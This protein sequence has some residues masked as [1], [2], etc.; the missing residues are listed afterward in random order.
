[1]QVKVTGGQTTT[2]SNNPFR[3]AGEYWAGHRGEY[4][5]R[6]RSMN[7]RTGR[8]TQPDPFFHSL[9]GNLQDCPWSVAQAGNLYMF[10]MHNPVMFIDPSGLFAELRSFVLYDSNNDVG[11]RTGAGRDP[12][13]DFGI[14]IDQMQNL[15]SLSL[16]MMIIM[17][18]YSGDL[19]RANNISMEFARL[20]NA[21]RT[22]FGS[23]GTG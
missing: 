21:G 17:G 22:V 16:N 4:Y 6:A 8:F 14:I 18:C 15:N 9:H 3:W 1:M 11:R 20:I 23:D 2:E 19:S 13:F 10:V 12:A 5:L 7:P